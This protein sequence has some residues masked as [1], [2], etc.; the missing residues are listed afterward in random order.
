MK[1]LLF[2]LFFW[3]S[4]VPLLHSADL[5]YSGLELTYDHFNF[6]RQE[7]TGRSVFRYSALEESGLKLL[8]E[9]NENTKPDGEVYL[10]K[11]VRYQLDSLQATHYTEEDLRKSL[12]IEN[13]Y[14]PGLIRSRLS[15]KG[16]VKEFELQV[17]K[18]GVVPFETV[19]LFLRQR[20]QE[21]GAGRP[22]KMSLYLPA[23]AFELERSGMPRSMSLIRMFVE[24]QGTETVDSVLGRVSAV[25]LLAYPESAMLRLLLPKS[26]THFRFLILQEA[27]HWILEFEEGETRHQLK[28]VVLP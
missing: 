7:V 25:R 4:G 28:K 14:L 27:P 26:K 24:S 15:E 16:Q 10:R 23:L 11:T 21:I 20:W 9:D 19:L 18:S 6:K 1:R 17:P 2:L 5:L 22:L 12:R 8:L 13:Q 3:G